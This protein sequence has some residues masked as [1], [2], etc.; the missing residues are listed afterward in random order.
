VIISWETRLMIRPMGVI[1]KNDTG[2]K[3]TRGGIASSHHGTWRTPPFD[4]RSAVL[5]DG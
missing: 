5:G 2:K 4:N 3:S 1:S